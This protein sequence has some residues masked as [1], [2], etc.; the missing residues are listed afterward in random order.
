MAILREFATKDIMNWK[1]IAEECYRGNKLLA[2][3]VE[4][5]IKCM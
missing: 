3:A 5:I 4:I 2:Y 1:V